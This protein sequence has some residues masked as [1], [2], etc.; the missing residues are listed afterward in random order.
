[1]VVALPATLVAIHARGWMMYAGMAAA[2]FFLLVNTGPLNA[3]LV[4]S[5]SAPI[6]SSAIA[7]NL[8]FIHLLGDAFSPAVIGFISDRSNL[9]TGF[10]AAVAA[11][12]LAA[13]FLFYGMRFAP[14][15]PL[16][17]A[18]ATEGTAGYAAS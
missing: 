2:A 1:M 11:I 6:R 17:A 10:L 8:F 14:E 4:N 18:P 9:E 13:A 7:V 3:A 5:V 15:A 16:A 12:V